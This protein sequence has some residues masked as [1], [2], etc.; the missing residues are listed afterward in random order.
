MIA[1]DPMMYSEK[2]GGVVTPFDAQK[3]F[4]VRAPELLFSVW[5]EDMTFVHVGADGRCGCAN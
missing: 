3:L 2:V 1:A 4:V 5:C